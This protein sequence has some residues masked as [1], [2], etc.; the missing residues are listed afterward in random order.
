MSMTPDFLVASNSIHD[1]PLDFGNQ[2]WETLEDADGWED[3][4]SS[5]GA[6]SG[7]GDEQVEQL[8]GFLNDTHPAVRY[9]AISRLRELEGSK[10]ADALIYALSDS[11][12]WVRIR[13]I[14]G[15]GDLRPPEAV[16]L[17]IQYLDKEV[18]PKVRA[19]LVKHLGRFQELR[20]IPIIAQYLQ[21]EDARVRANT[22]EGLGFYQA[23]LV[24]EILKPFLGDSHPRIRAN[25]AVVLSK[26]EN[27]KASKTLEEMLVSQNVYERMGAIYSIGELKEEKYLSIL[28]DALHDPSYLVQRNVRDALAKYGIMVQGPLLKEIRTKKSYHFVLGAIQVLSEIGD[29]KSLK[30]L[31]KLQETGDG[32]IRAA[33]EQAVDAICSRT[34]R[35]E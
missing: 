22:V 20:L 3:R 13:A 16:E 9:A 6:V 11:Y 25:V 18:N 33:A 23:D 12:E 27:L 26:V 8:R 7:K 28:F 31:L 21:D 35:D 14:E 29:K 5:V 15:L 10:V 24:Q 17:F 34:D 2:D 19:T 32:E 1:D 4:Y 30:T